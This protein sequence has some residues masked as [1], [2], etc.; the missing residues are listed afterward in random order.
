MLCAQIYFQTLLYFGGVRG[1][2]GFR[3]WEQ[4]RVITLNARTSLVWMGRYLL[5][6]FQRKLHSEEDARC[7]YYMFL[8]REGSC[9][10]SLRC[11]VQSCTDPRANR[12]QL[13][14]QKVCH[15]V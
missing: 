9:T 12:G 1:W 15:L 10:L 2:V 14:L 3:V 6:R 13:A 7:V 5:A 8:L 4:I 11:Q